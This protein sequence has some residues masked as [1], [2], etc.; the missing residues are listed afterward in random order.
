MS[1]EVAVN[2]DNSV[3][4]NYLYSTVLAAET[5]G[6][7][8]FEY[9]KG[10]REFFQS[11]EIYLVAGGKAVSEF[12]NLCERRKLLYEDIEDFIVETGE[13]IFEYSL[14][15]EDDSFNSND[16]A[17]LR[18]GVQMNMHMYETKADQLSVIRRCFQQMGECKRHILNSELEET[19][20]QEHDPE[21]RSE[22][23]AQLDINHDAEI[24][25]DA[26]YIEK[27]QGVCVLAA[28]DSDITADTHQEI[29]LDIVQDML[30]PDIHID[31]IDP[32][33]TTTEDLLN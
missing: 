15:W 26:A 13:G 7:A 16:Q 23:D 9:D 31:I 28:I 1:D 20:D 21:L 14:G 18:K 30:D 24:L 11:S 27:K 33:D 22:I 10:C 2:V 29:F 32:E 6:D 3:I 4:V 17:H 25:V 12:E 5:D 8:E 19:F